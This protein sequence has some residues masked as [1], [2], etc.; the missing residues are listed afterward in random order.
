MYVS[1]TWKDLPDIL[2]NANSNLKIKITD[3]ENVVIG[4]SGISG[5]LGY[6]I[7]NYTESYFLDFT[8]SDFSTSI[9][10]TNSTNLFYSCTNLSGMCRLPSSITN[11]NYMF[12]DCTGL[13][14]IDTSTFTNVTSAWKMFTRCTR[15]TSIDT[16]AFTN[17]SNANS[18]FQ[19]C[20]ELTSIDT[21]AF[22]NVTIADWMFINCI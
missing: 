18:M 2:K 19:Y 14:S 10:T 1:T 13:T 20:T 9:Y 11:A 21:T 7:K 4:D 6:L 15:L 8:P 3:P 12:Y 22:T 16:T 5:T 17:V